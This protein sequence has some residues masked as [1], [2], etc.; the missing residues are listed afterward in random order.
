MRNARRKRS[1]IGSSNDPATE[2]LIRT[3]VA[4]CSSPAEALELYYWS[5]EP[6]LIEVIRGIATMPEDTRAAIEAFI[7]LARDAKSIKA[8]A[9]RA[10]RADARFGRSRAD[11]R[12]RATCGRRGRRRAA[13]AQL[14]FPEPTL[15]CGG[16]FDGIAVTIS[17][18]AAT[19]PS[20]VR[21]WGGKA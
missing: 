1:N 19:C 11:G 6:G 2:R 3:L 5:R 14:I 8:E 4:G 9:R 12:A 20:C 10:R 18:V 17:C 13:I 7:A 16:R 15:Y 21:L